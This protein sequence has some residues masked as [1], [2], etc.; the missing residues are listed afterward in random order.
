MLQCS[1]L[2][3]VLLPLPSLLERY[4]VYIGF[5]TH[6]INNK[7]IHI[8]MTKINMNMVLYCLIN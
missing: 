8:F 5:G 1:I 2:K 7:F 6:N 4:F 3:L